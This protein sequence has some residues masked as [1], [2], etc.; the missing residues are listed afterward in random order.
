MYET[1]RIRP[2]PDKNYM[3]VYILLFDDVVDTDVNDKVEFVYIS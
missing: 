2:P 3:V 1:I